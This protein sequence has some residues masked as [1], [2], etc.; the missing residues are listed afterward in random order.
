[1]AEEKIDP[2]YKPSVNDA[3]DTSNFSEYPDSPEEPPRVAVE[4]DPFAKW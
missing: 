3:G 4:E 1:L 2:P